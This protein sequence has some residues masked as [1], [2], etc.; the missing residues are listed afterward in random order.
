MM[1]DVDPDFRRSDGRQRGAQPVLNCG[2]ERDGNIYVLGCCRGF[3]QQF[4]ARKER[5]FLEHAFLVPDAYAFPQFL[6]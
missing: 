5:I 1:V 6:E 3:R 2:V 4:S